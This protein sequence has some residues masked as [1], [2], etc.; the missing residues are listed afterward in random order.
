MNSI[1]DRAAAA[2]RRVERSHGRGNSSVTWQLAGERD[3]TEREIAECEGGGVPAGTLKR[4]ARVLQ[5][6]VELAAGE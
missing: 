4:K 5:R 3:R 1:E 6:A 2:V